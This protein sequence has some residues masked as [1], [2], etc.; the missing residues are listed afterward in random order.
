MILLD[1]ITNKDSCVIVKCITPVNIFDVQ[2]HYLL[3]SVHAAGE[4]EVGLER[5]SEA[6]ITILLIFETFWL[7]PLPPNKIY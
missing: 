7:K 6:A 5:V 2:Y 1:L 3:R 4:G